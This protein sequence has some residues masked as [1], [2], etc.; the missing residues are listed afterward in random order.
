[1]SLDGDLWFFDLRPYLARL[2]TSPQLA[3]LRAFTLQPLRTSCTSD[4]VSL[5]NPTRAPVDATLVAHLPRAGAS[6]PA[7]GQAGDEPATSVVRRLQLAPGTT[8]IALRGVLYSTLTSDALAHFATPGPVPGM[9][10]PP[11]S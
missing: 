7:D 4:S 1:V 2:R 5:V 11:C 8:T 9:T 10:G 3:L 6:L